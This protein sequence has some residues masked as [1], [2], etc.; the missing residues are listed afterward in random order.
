LYRAI[1]QSQPAYSDANHN[2][3]AI[4]VSVDKPDAALTLF[5]IILQANSKIEQFRLGYIDILIKEK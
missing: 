3:E 4:A 1:S 2:L 5:K